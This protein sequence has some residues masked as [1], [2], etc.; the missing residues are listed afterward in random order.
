MDSL[1][2]TVLSENRVDNPLLI[3]EQGLSIYIESG[4]YKVLFDT[5]QEKAICHN[6]VHLG[7]NMRDLNYIILSHGHYD[8]GGGLYQYLNKYHDATIISHPS[9]FNKKYLKIDEDKKYLGLNFTL[10]E[11]KNLGGHFI[12]KS[13]AFE[14]IPNFFYSGEINR[15][16]EYENIEEEYIERILESDIHDELHDD[17]ALYIK[18]LKGLIILL[19]CGHAGVINTIK[20]G[21]RV[22]NMRKVHAVIGGMHLKKASDEK[23]EQIVTGLNE[24]DIERI[25]P[26]HCTG[27]R[28]ISRLISEFGDKVILFNVGDTLQV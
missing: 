11:M 27:F 7:L 8:H 3:A 4:N 24:I 28:A 18:T 9:V 16:T 23:I 17:S 12:F 20:H 19:G 1:K 22:T 6:A 26:L 21:M 14:F 15:I 5:G 10:D 13:K 2:L 25:I